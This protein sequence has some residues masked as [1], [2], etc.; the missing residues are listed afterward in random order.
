[1]DLEGFYLIYSTR[2]RFPSA[3]A[4]GYKIEVSKDGQHWDTAVDQSASRVTD[5]E[6]ADNL[7]A[8]TVIRY[9]RLTFPANAGAPPVGQA[10][11]P[12]QFFGLAEVS[13]F[14]LMW[15]E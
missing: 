13:L 2:I 12:A 9:L 8:G 14:G 15:A 3:G 5:A 6:R 1:V 4:H 7:P 10:L 11:S